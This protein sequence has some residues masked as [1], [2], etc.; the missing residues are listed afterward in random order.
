MV[1]IILES[2]REN[3]HEILFALG[4]GNP[5]GDSVQD[6]L[7]RRVQLRNLSEA[8]LIFEVAED[9]LSKTELG[10]RRSSNILARRGRERSASNAQFS[11]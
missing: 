7:E 3:V 2:D 6:L 11:H 4:R 9:E 8:G 1:N 10:S 5:S